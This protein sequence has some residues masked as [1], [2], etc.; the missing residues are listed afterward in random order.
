MPLYAD[1]S[2]LRAHQNSTLAV[3]ILN[4]RDYSELDLGGLPE[5]N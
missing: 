2:E 5:G 4:K 3:P 1:T